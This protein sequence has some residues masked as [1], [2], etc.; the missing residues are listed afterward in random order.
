MAVTT[1]GERAILAIAAVAAVY[2]C[3]AIAGDRETISAAVYRRRAWVRP[4]FLFLA[5]H[6]ERVIPTRL[7]PLRRWWR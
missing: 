2:D 1:E 5:L 7:D 4:L 3:W 6:F